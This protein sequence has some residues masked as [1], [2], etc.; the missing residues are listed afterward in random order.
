[1]K[2]CIKFTV[3]FVLLML[4]VSM[5]GAALNLMSVC[6]KHCFEAC[7]STSEVSGHSSSKAA[8][9]SN[10]DS[11]IAD[12]ENGIHSLSFSDIEMGFKP[13]SETYSFQN[14]QR[15]RRAVELSDFFKG[16]VRGLCLR[17]NL[18]VLDKS[19]SCHLD[20]S[21]YIAQSGCEYYVF[22]LRRILI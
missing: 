19:R 9:L 7:N 1:M 15:M 4:S 22:T 13:L 6:E 18:L 14:S 21:L 2:P 12:D 11:Y 20:R 16:L 10:T 5:R 8:V 3:I 17:E